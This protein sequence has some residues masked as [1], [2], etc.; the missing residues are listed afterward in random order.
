MLF[1]EDKWQNILMQKI[2][3]S[4]RVNPEKNASQTDEQTNRWIDEQD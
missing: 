1:L 3:K 2:K 4:R